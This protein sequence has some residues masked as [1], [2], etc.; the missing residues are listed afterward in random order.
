MGKIRTAFR[1]ITA[2]TLKSKASI[3]AQTD[4][5]VVGNTID[6]VNIS[7][8]QVKNVIGASTFSVYDVCRHD[9]V[10]VWSQFG[11]TIRIYTGV[12]TWSAALVNSKPTECKLADFAGYQHFTTSVPGYAFPENPKTVYVNSGSKATVLCDVNIGGFDYPDV[13]SNPGIAFVLFDSGGVI[14]GWSV[15]SLNNQTETAYLSLDT[16][17]V[18]SSST[19]GW[20]AGVYITT[21]DTILSPIDIQG[22]VKCRLPNAATFTVNIVVRQPRVVIYAHTR[23]ITPPSPW[24]A[25]STNMN[26]TSGELTISQLNSPNNETNLIVSASLV[27]F[28]NTEIGNVEIFNRNYT[29]FSN[30]SGTWYLGM[31][32]IPTHGYTVTIFVS[33]TLQPT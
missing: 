8:T 15:I 13:G 10:N 23:T 30:I 16:I 33:A 3:P 18:V 19:S 14:R 20:Y 1:Q 32:N 17:D 2:A 28:T 7:L 26:W 29:A 12:G 5:T 6:C 11:P 25:S 24:T 9:N 21:V 22:H 4:I 27:D 31:T